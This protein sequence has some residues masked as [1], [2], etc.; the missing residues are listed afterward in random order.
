M[1]D[2]R[3]EFLVGCAARSGSP[4]ED[5]W[6]ESGLTAMRD[7]TR[8]ARD[9]KRVLF[10]DV[11]LS[12]QGLLGVINVAENEVTVDYTL[13]VGNWNFITLSFTVIYST[14]AGTP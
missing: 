6:K 8:L 3:V 2:G 9:A 7:K 12:G 1:L 4:T 14:P 11:Q 13:E 10:T 5:V